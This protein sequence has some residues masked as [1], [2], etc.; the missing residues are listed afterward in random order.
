MIFVRSGTASPDFTLSDLASWYEDVHIPA[1]LATGGVT[2]AARY[3]LVPD[4]TGSDEGSDEGVTNVAYLTVY[5]LPDM[6]WLHREDCG[7]WKL[8]LDVPGKVE[9]EKRSIFEVADF[10]TLFWELIGREDRVG[11]APHSGS[12]TTR[13]NR[14]RLES[15]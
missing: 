7:F 11:N 1:V 3:Q 14:P 15:C 12:C 13:P 8:P 2:A 4:P 5:H 9:G 6:N 10:E